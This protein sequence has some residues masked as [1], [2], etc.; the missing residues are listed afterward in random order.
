MGAEGRPRRVL[1]VGATSAIAAEVA[2][3]YAAGGASLVL[4]GRNPARLAAVGDDLRVRGAGSVETEVLDLLDR[5]RHAAV[6]KRA[7][8]GPLDV[9]L[10][11]HGDLPDQQRCQTDP[12]EAARALELNLVATVELL[13]L[14]ASEFEAQG[15]GTIAVITSVAGDRGR[16]SNYVYGAAKAGVSVF[17]QGLRQRLR[18]AGVR[19]VTLKPG[20]VDT[21]M[22]AHLARN[23][24]ASSPQRAA[25][26]IYRAIGSRRDVAYIPWFWRP[27]MALI[28]AVPE[29]LFKR[30]HL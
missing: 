23:P 27:V 4:T 15:F 22:T 16:Q 1:I 7:F 12:G 21:P 29:S 10:L 19:V 28:R 6:V 8:A 25:R 14:L 18:A 11:A 24:L 26:A 2:R 20:F 3:R 17:L 13:T 5:E 30:L 9:A